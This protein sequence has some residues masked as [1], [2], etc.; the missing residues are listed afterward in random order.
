V[1]ALRSGA[2]T[3]DDLAVS[4]SGLHQF[5]HCSVI[6]LAFFDIFH[7]DLGKIPLSQV[8]TLISLEKLFV[9]V[10]MPYL[11]LSLCVISTF[12]HR[13]MLRLCILLLSLTQ[14][15][16]CLCTRLK[17]SCSERVK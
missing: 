6:F 5:L 7:S 9:Y 10:L 8:S 13:L 1:E 4:V 11:T 3:W 16:H 15:K 17:A 2:K 12:H 14:V